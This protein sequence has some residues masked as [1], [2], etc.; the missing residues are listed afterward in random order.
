MTAQQFAENEEKAKARVATAQYR[1]DKALANYD[2]YTG[3]NYAEEKRLSLIWQDAE[4]KKIEA[5][6]KL[7]TLQTQYNNTEKQQLQVA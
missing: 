6:K 7:L 3:R 2:T 4:I 1:Y 5:E